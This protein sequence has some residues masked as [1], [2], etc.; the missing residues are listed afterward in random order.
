M[1]KNRYALL[2]AV[3]CL[4][5]VLL[6][7][8]AIRAMG[9]KAASAKSSCSW[10]VVPAPTKGSGVHLAGMAAL[11]ANDVWS[12]GSYRVAGSSGTD[13]GLIE[14]WNGTQWNIIP[15]PKIGQTGSYLSGIAAVSTND[16]WA[17]GTY[18]DSTFTGHLLIEH[19]NGT[20][21]HVVPAPVPSYQGGS[22]S[23]VSVISANDIWA[24][25]TYYN[26]QYADNTLAV[27]WNGKQWS[28]VPTPNPW[29]DGDYLNAV[30][31]ISSN[32]VWAVGG[33]FAGRSD[34]TLTEHWDGT[35]WSVVNSPNLSLNLNNLTGVSASS[36]SDVWA[37]GWAD[38]SGTKTL[39]EHW[40]GSK[41]SI[42]KS[43]SVFNAQNLLFQ[44][45][46]LNGNNAWAVGY[47]LP[48]PPHSYQ[49]TLIEHWNGTKW[50]IVAS[51]NPGPN[52][53]ALYSVTRVPSSQQ[54]WA[55]GTS[56][57][58]YGNPLAAVHC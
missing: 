33:A 3:P 42:A 55:M 40:D 54:V 58:N 2:I 24:V 19:W 34:L 50:S 51:P 43:A 22:L 14:N 35:K 28:I 39:I 46:A 16:L 9:A 32:D 23:S 47:I 12:A 18:T 31:A 5:V 10:Q 8:F 41:W 15:S 6:A 52:D 30:V 38:S 53:N 20:T 49:Q 44:V 26:S 4:I 37:V 27:H 17:V 13:Y 21:W 36:A 1:Q 29:N 48:K 11:S 56:G 7:A 45:T 57:S 25:G